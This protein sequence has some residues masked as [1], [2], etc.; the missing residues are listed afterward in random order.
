MAVAQVLGPAPT[1]VQTLFDALC[2]H[3]RERRVLLVLDNLE[4]LLSEAVVVANLLAAC[5]GLVVLAT[6]REPLRLRG[7]RE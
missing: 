4:H 7:E 6:S 2:A 5:P 1:G 3:L